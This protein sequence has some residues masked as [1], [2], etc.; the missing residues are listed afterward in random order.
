MNKNKSRCSGEEVTALPVT[1]KDTRND[2]GNNETE[3]QEEGEIP[4]V[5]PPHNFVLAQIA[6]VGNT[7]LT[8]GFYKH[9]AYMREPESLVGIVW[10]QVGVSIPVVG[11]VAPGPPLD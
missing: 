9:P 8:S 7:R 11:T 5:L 4:T 1:P 2:R 6:D 10:I 3:E